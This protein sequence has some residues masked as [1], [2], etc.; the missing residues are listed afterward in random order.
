MKKKIYKIGIWGQFGDGGPIADGQAVRTTITTN[1][2]KKRYGDD[3]VLI[4]NTNA[5]KKHPIKFFLDTVNL[6]K[7]SENILIFPADNGLKVVAQIYDIFNVFFKRKLFY[8]V[9]GGFLPAFLEKNPR[10]IK[11]LNKYEVLFVQKPNLKKDLGNL[12]IKNI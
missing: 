3:N 2:L 4:L 10:Y 8:I 5:W 12:G 11:I 1:E 9:I 7:K 6:L